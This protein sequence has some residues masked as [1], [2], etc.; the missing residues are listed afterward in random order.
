MTISEQA[1]LHQAA[2]L[3]FEHK[4]RHLPVM[5]G[6]EVVGVV[7]EGDVALVNGLPVVDPGTVL[8]AHAMTRRPFICSPD[9]EMVEVVRIMRSRKIGSALVMEEGALVGIF[10]VTD[11]LRV[12]EEQLSA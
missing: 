7:S 5:K 1:T 12:F 2:C 9:E 8:V 4:I 3:M 11:A 6:D 10:S